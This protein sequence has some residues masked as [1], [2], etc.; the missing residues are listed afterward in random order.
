[1]N[2]G[3]TPVMTVNGK[4]HVFPNLLSNFP[5]DGLQNSGALS[6]LPHTSLCFEV[7][8]LLFYLIRF[9]NNLK[10]NS[11]QIRS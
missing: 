4:P 3:K 10:R 6:G 5:N 2:S 11:L 9:L 7:T 1:M 8:L